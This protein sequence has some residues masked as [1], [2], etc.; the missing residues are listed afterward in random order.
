MA[1]GTNKI[2]II[3]GPNLNMLG[4]REPDV[5]G[6]ETL[7]DISAMCDAEA[8]NLDLSIDFRQSN[9]EGQ[10]ITWI[11]DARDSFQ[12]IIINPAAFTHTSIAIMDALLAVGLPVVE[13]HLSNIHKRE[14][15]RHQSYVSLMAKGVICGF[16]SHGYVLALQAMA[17]LLE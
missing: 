7:A 16:G 1:A 13:V 17:R 12:G 3:N 10:I 4:M 11:Q 8:I 2:L 5:Y 6:Y 14:A 9:T 15:F